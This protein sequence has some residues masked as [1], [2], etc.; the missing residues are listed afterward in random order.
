MYTSSRISPGFPDTFWNDF[1]VGGVITGQ[2]QSSECRYPIFS[3]PCVKD[4]VL[5]A[6]MFLVLL[7]EIRWLFVQCVYF[8]VLYSFPLAFITVILLLFLLLS[9]QYNS[10]SSIMIPPAL[11][12]LLLLFRVFYL[13][14]LIFSLLQKL[15][16]QF[17]W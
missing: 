6:C 16:L 10:N 2:F 9:L 17:W 14:G 5:S 13:L 12:Y 8:C 1:R 4:A 11:H 7:S 15:T 3:G